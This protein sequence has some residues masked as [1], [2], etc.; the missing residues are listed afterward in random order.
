MRQQLLVNYKY[1][2]GIVHYIQVSDANPSYL[3]FETAVK[4]EEMTTICYVFQMI[5]VV[6]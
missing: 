3:E 4:K 6:H 2:N 5:D 1:F